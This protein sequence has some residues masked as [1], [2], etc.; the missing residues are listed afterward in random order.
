[1]FSADGYRSELREIPV[2]QTDTVGCQACLNLWQTVRGE[3]FAPSWPA[4]DLLQLPSDVVPFISVV[5]VQFEPLDFKYRY[6]GTGHVQLKNEERTGI[7]VSEIMPEERAEL[8]Y[9]E[10]SMVFE[11]RQPKAFAHNRRTKDNSFPLAHLNLRL[12]LS[13]DGQR[14]DKIVTYSSHEVEALKWVG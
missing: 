6:W 13:D 5:D 3:V 2:D 1:M 10:Y 7:L 9:V 11:T 8:N 14:D 4:F 12:P